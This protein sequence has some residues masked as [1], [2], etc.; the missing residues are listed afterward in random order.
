MW[1]GNREGNKPYL[2]GMNTLLKHG[3]D[4]GLKFKINDESQS[5]LELAKSRGLDEVVALLEGR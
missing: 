1:S 5:A 2:E 4:P 3:A